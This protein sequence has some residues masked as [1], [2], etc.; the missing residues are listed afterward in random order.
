MRVRKVCREEAIYCRA[1]SAQKLVDHERSLLRPHC[2]QY[3]A[4]N[5]AQRHH[6]ILDNAA[7]ARVKQCPRDR[8][9]RLSWRRVCAR[10]VRRVDPAPCAASELA[11]CAAAEFAF[12]FLCGGTTSTSSSELSAANR[13]A[14]M[15]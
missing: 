10:A 11:P 8:E 3:G 13:S 12:V 1:S 7:A 14:A 2:R 5:L 4:H 9:P 6:P 15:S